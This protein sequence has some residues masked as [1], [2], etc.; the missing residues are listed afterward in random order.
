MY[1]G[2]LGIFSVLTALTEYVVV[3]F[4]WVFLIVASYVV[5]KVYP[6]VQTKKPGT[7]RQR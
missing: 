7:L 3:N 4:L 1:H 5:G 2:Y 6:A